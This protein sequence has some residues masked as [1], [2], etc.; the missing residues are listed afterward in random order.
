MIEK[1]NAATLP[2]HADAEISDETL[3]QS[4]AD[5]D[6]TALKVLYLRHRVRIDR[7][8]A[9]LIGSDSI[10]DEVVNDVFVA[11]WRHARQ[12]EGKS[13]VATWLQGIAR[14]KAISQCRRRSEAL[15]DPRAS[16]LIQ[17]PADDPVTSIE[18]RH[19]T[20]ILQKCLA[21]LR[22][23]HRDVIALIYYQGRKIEEVAHLTGKPVS[24]IKTRLHYVRIRVAEALAEVGVYRAWLAV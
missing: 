11:V 2:T 6:K 14:F 9:R 1:F 19:R 20:D 18:K 7:Y 4:I 5:R 24:I 22:P 15:P 16:T 21:T 10:T 3:V 12:F 8:A 13:Q 23:I 17:D